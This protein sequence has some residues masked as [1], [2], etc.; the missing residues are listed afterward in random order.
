MK[1]TSIKIVLIL[2][3]SVGAIIAQTTEFTYQGTL[4]EG[5]S[6]ANANYDFE[7]LLFDAAGAG[8]QLGPTLSR[9]GVSVA[10]GA[11][12]VNLDFGDQFPGGGQVS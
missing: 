12:A 2:L 9:N 3:A 6:P 4:R 10:N 8:T 11:F 1:T 7:F 5:G